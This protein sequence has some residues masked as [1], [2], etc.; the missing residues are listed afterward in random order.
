MRERGASRRRWVGTAMAVSAWL[1]GAPTVAQ[2]AD[3]GR[4]VHVR[5]RVVPA[6]A[7]VSVDGQRVGN[8][9]D[10]EFAADATGHRVEAR[11]EGYSPAATVIGPPQR[12][13][14]CELRLARSTPS[15]PA[16]RATP[17]ARTALEEAA[18]FNAGA[19]RTHQRG[20]R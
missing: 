14:R 3:A 20:A 11:R 4:V 17:P 13:Q 6:D 16:Q 19:F 2:E 7:E 1:C 15:A 5:I 8:P 9:A 10:V 18:G 12:L